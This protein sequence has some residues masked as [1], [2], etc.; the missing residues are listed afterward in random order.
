MT[1]LLLS[2]FAIT[3]ALNRVWAFQTVARGNFQP[4][5]VSMVIAARNKQQSKAERIVPIF[6][7]VC[8]TTGVTLTRFMMEVE[9]LNPELQ[10]LAQLFSGIQTACKAISNLVRRSQLPQSA[11][12]GYEGAINVQG[13]AQKVTITMK[14]LLF[15]PWAY[16]LLSIFQL[17]EIGCNHKSCL[18]NGAAIYRHCWGSCIRGRRCTSKYDIS[19]KEQRIDLR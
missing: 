12:L 2:F 7:E 8:E 11:V 13:E 19:E 14:Y 3:A 18:E 16:I 9:K 5:H 1:R 17:V 15:H 6:D 10:E 4:S